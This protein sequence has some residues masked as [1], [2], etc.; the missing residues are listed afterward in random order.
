MIKII[1]ILTA[2][3]A[4]VACKANE[5]VPTQ[6]V[7]EI[8]AQIGCDNL[9][10]PLKDVEVEKNRTY[11]YNY[12]VYIRCGDGS[13]RIQVDLPKDHSVDL[14]KEMKNV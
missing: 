10:M 9:G 11:P 8:M 1:A 13:V 7:H 12:I 4:L 5:S 3:V 6:A 14:P 2:C